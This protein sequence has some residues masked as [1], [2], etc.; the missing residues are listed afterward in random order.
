[1]GHLLLR[2]NAMKT[3][4]KYS[5]VLTILLGCS[6]GATATAIVLPNG[7]RAQHIE[8]SSGKLDCLKKASYLCPE[9]YDVF[10]REER[11]ETTTGDQIVNYVVVSQ[12]VKGVDRSESH[13]HEMLI[14]CTRRG[15][16]RDL[17]VQGHQPS[18]Q[19]VPET[20]DEPRKVASPVAT[21]SSGEPIPV[22][23]AQTCQS[24]RDGLERTV[25]MMSHDTCTDTYGCLDA[26]KCFEECPRRAPGSTPTQDC[27]RECIKGLD[28][29]ARLAARKYLECFYCS[30]TCSEHCQAERSDYRSF[31]FDLV[32]S[33][34]C[35]L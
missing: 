13:I 22:G 20:T 26:I 8:C 12:G 28:Q 16:G 10:E 23:N 33:Q 19:S 14:A 35:A 4:I 3:S 31:M 27:T 25:C 15:Q 1:M 2:V 29:S 5:L 17:T 32:P 21:R 34:A 24:C 30:P 7:R 11:T 6:G 9:G 18:E